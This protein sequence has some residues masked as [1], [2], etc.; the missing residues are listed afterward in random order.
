MR[1]ILVVLAIVLV[2]TAI[3]SAS[4]ASQVALAR[5]SGPASPS[6]PREYFYSPDATTWIGSEEPYG[7]GQVAGT[8]WVGYGP[9]PGTIPGTMRGL[10]KFNM[11]QLSGGINITS[12]WLRRR[13]CLGTR[14]VSSVATLTRSSTPEPMVV[15]VSVT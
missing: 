12:A 4:R 11:D 7:S 9:G 13:A 1:R 15:K 10:V 6:Q 2:G 5:P 3:A 14:L 8:M